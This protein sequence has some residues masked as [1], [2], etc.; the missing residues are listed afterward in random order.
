MSPMLGI[1]AS[2][3][4]GSISSSSFESIATINLSGTSTGSFTSIPA[5]Y[6]SLQL[7]FITTSNLASYMR[8]NGASTS[9]DYNGHYLWGDGT[10]VYA[11]SASALTSTDT[12]YPG[13]GPQ[14]ATN[15]YVGIIDIHDYAST[16]KN[17]T[18]R[19]L[20]GQESNNSNS[21]I[22]IT[23]GLRVSTAAIS[24]IE[25]YVLS[26]TFAAGSSIAL[27]GIKGA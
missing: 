22:F 26:S 9:G 5:T 2:S 6:V 23:S 15:P 10:A 7:R 27:Y 14:T 12:L 3:I 8:F 16:T 21:R 17:K 11:S 13:S 4:S 18:I 25:F 24:S 1:M 20:V 19:N